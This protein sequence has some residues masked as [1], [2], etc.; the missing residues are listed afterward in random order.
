[1]VIEF[2]KEYLKELY[3]NSEIENRKHGVQPSIVKKYIQTI[4]KLRAANSVEE[5]YPI[6]SINYERPLGN[7]KEL[8]TIRI[9]NEH[10]IEFK[11]KKSL[12]QQITI[13]LIIDIS[14]HY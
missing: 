5:L 6:K 7:K 8:E 10:R 2:D 12:Y 11:T 13:C 1:M 9:D 14:N 3:I 4:D